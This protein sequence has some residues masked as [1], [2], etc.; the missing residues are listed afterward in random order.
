MWVRRFRDF[1]RARQVAEGYKA[2]ADD[3]IE[4]MLTAF[5]D[6][7]ERPLGEGRLGLTEIFHR[8]LPYSGKMSSPGKHPPSIISKVTHEFIT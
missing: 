5:L 8:F 2:L 1:E 3:Q 6:Q 4:H 7:H